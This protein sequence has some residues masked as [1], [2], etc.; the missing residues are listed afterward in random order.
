M[1]SAKTLDK[2]TLLSFYLEC[3]RVE[4]YE[5]PCTKAIKAKYQSQKEL[6]QQRQAVLI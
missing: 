5:G 4:G 6:H 1:K 2:E 3:L